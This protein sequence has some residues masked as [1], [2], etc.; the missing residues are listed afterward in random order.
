MTPSEYFHKSIKG[1]IVT[2]DLVMKQGERESTL[3]GGEYDFIDVMETNGKK[4]YVCNTWHKEHRR[5]PLYIMED[6]VKL[7][8]EA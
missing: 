7:V 4:I 8:I 6:L 2:I 1:Q 5:E 3:V